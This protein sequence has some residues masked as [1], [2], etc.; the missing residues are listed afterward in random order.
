VRTIYFDRGFIVFAASNSKSD[1]LGQCLLDAGKITEHELELAARLMNGKRRI[2]EAIVEAGY[3][4][5][6]EIGRALAN[7][8]R[9]IAT[10]LFAVE[11]GMYRFDQQEC[12]SRAPAELLSYT[13]SSSRASAR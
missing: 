10:S 6:D 2:G 4:S 12:D 9:R 7:Q 8:A 13:A 1:R 3:L 5:Q 11:E